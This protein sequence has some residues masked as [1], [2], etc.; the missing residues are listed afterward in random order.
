MKVLIKKIS[1][2]IIKLLRMQIVLQ[3]KFKFIIKKMLVGVWAMTYRYQ[4]DAI[5]MNY[6]N[7]GIS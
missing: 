4:F 6:V 1:L 2:F 3:V 5:W 7:I